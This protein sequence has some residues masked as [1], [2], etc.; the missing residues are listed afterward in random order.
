MNLIVSKC[1]QGQPKKG[2]HQGAEILSKY[3]QDNPNI[4]IKNIKTKHFNNKLKGYQKIFQE[5]NKTFQQNKLPINLGGDHSISGATL[6]SSIKNFGDDLRV[7]W[8]DAH[9]DVNTIESSPSGN[10]HGMPIA[11]ALHLMKPWVSAPPLKPEQIIYIGLR[12]LDP[13]EEDFIKDKNIIHYTSEDVGV[14]GMKDILKDFAGHITNKKIH[15]SFDIDSMDPLIAPSTGT[16]VKNGLLCHDI[17]YIHNKMFELG[18][19]VNCDFVEYNPEIG[20]NWDNEMTRNTY[21]KI[22][23]QFMSL[24]FKN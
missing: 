21:R 24:Y 4:S 10:F 22:L 6:A 16:P 5:N 13:F 20:N 14:F 7:I 1:W 12:D 11:S 18:N 17:Y 15:Y 9:A 23:N 8:V 19:V 2:V 3:F